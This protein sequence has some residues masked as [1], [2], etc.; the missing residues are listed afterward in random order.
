MNRNFRLVLMVEER[1]WESQGLCWNEKYYF[2]QTQAE[3]TCGNKSAWRTLPIK[4][5][6]ELS[7]EEQKEIL[8]CLS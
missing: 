4:L 8:A 3:D 2:L 7:P 1:Y 6:S 5:H